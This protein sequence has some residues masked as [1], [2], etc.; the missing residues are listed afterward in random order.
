M[1]NPTRVDAI[2]YLPQSEL[3]FVRAGQPVELRFDHLPGARFAGQV[4]ELSLHEVRSVPAPLSALYG[5][6]LPAQR[7]RD[8]RLQ[9]Q[10]TLYWARVGLEH[11]QGWLVPGMCGRARITVEHSSLGQRVWHALAG[12]VRFGR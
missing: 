5:G 6:P 8:G 11:P 7:Q 4:D 9:P 1:G 2:L 12:L 3:K 10:E